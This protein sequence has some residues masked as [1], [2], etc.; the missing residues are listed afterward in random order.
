MRERYGEEASWERH[1]PS[2]L[3]GWQLANRPD[4]HERGWNEAE[5]DVRDEWQRRHPDRAWSAVAGAVEPGWAS[6]RGAPASERRPRPGAGP[7]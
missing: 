4:L 6:A 1:M 2:Y 7:R 5:T 3:F